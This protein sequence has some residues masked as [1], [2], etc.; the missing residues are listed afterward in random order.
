MEALK[1]KNRHLIP[2]GNWLATLELSGS[3]SRKRTRFVVALQGRLDEMEKERIK[4]AEKYCKKNNKGKPKMKKDAS[5]Q[6]VYDFSKENRDKFANEMNEYFEEDYVLDVL[7]SNKEELKAIKDVVLNTEEKFSGRQATEY[8]E[9][10][11]AFEALN[12]D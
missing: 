6:Q 4:L 8:D 1:L 5:G 11:E 7:D 9:W 10:C 2:L 12:L 3:D